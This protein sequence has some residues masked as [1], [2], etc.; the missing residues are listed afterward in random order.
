MNDMLNPNARIIR[1][2]WINGEALR[3]FLDEHPHRAVWALMRSR[4]PN[5]STVG[6]SGHDIERQPMYDRLQNMASE[7][8]WMAFELTE[9]NRII[10]VSK[11]GAII[12]YQNHTHED[13]LAFLRAYIL[14][15]VSG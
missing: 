8:S 9:F 5:W 4:L 1:R 7:T 15:L 13:F 12:D 10:G 14:P 3:K 2:V 6:V 11:N